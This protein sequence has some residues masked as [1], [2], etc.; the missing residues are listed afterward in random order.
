MG[1]G[2]DEVPFPQHTADRNFVGAAS[3]V[4][5]K[6]P[7]PCFSLAVGTD[8]GKGIEQSRAAIAMWP[9]LKCV[10]AA[11][12]AAACICIATGP[13]VISAFLPGDIVLI[14]SFQKARNG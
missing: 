9:T 7:P 8:V 11:V 2:C 14:Y 4:V 1:P 5:S 10:S 3:K 12:L 13:R 6:Q